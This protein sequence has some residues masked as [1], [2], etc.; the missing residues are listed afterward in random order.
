MMVP[1]QILAIGYFTMVWRLDLVNNFLPLIL[2]AMA[3]PIVVFFMRQY[4]LA[5]F[6]IDIV[7]SARIDGAREFRIFN[8]IVLPMM[9]PA[10]ATQAI[11]IFVASWNA[12]F[13]PR[14]LLTDRD[15]FTMPLMVSL[16]QGNIYDTE[17][18]VV[19]LGLTLS[20][21]PIFLVYFL[22]ARYIIAGI[23]LGAVKG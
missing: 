21:L 13:L 2:P 23:Q 22:L 9:K 3:S 1:A 12:L 16:L 17:F 18:G 11:F 6:Q 19:Y 8:Q 14:I 20:I 7:N 4:L 15:M 10:I 5:T